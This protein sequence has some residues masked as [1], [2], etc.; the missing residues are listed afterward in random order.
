MI[1]IA[2]FQGRAFVISIEKLFMYAP[3]SEYVPQRVPQAAATRA[4]FFVWG[5]LCALSLGFL[6]LVL[7]APILL[8]HGYTQPATLI[9]RAFG[10]LCHQ[11][12]ERSFHLEGHALGVCARCT[13]IYS[14]IAVST[15]FYPV[16]RSLRRTE[17]P[18]RIWLVLACVPIAVD[19][20]LGYFGIWPNTHFSRFAT[21]AIFGAV[22]ALFVI[23]G[24]LDLRRAMRDAE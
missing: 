10:F 12:P 23:P 17:T 11:I 5:A 8:A 15:L 18:A 6:G 21:G 3:T 20:A 2:Q 22:C 16:V 13:G 7:A 24:F 14:G 19:F 4:A 9:Y 1:E